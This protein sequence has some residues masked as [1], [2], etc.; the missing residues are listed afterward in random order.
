MLDGIAQAGREDLLDQWRRVYVEIA[1]DT[2]VFLQHDGYGV[3]RQRSGAAPARLAMTPVIH[4]A[5]PGFSVSR[6]HIHLFVGANA[7]SLI[8]GQ[9]LPVDRDNLKTG[10]GCVARP[11]NIGRSSGALKSCGVCAGT[12][13]VPAPSARSSS[14]HGTS[15]SRA[16]SGGVP[17]L[18]ALGGA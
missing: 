2:A 17:W 13:R 5:I 18:A 12:S 4:A 10:L 1:E 6:W 15:T 8:D 16:S 7:T 3:D 11:R 9:V 14:R